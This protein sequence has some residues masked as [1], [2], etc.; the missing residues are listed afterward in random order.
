MRPEGCI[1][2]ILVFDTFTTFPI[3]KSITR[4]EQILLD[5]IRVSLREMYK[6]TAALLVNA[7]LQARLPQ[8]TQIDLKP[9]LRVRGYREKERNIGGAIK[10]RPHDGEAIMD[11]RRSHNK[12]IWLHTDTPL[13]RRIFG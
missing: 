11:H 4:D 8:A 5:A 13:P 12:T 6:I 1:S 3:G 10:N 9:E 7:A 2:S